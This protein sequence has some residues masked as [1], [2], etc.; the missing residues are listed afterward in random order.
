MRLPALC[1]ALAVLLV[2]AAA[3]AQIRCASG[4]S[5][6]VSEVFAQVNAL[7][8]KGGLKALRMDS[9]LTRAAQ[10]HGCEMRASGFFAHESPTTGTAGER[11]KRAGYTWCRVTENLAKGQDTP[12]QAVQGWMS[13]KG[14]RRNILDGDVVE[15]GI[16]LVPEGPDGGP[17]W[18]QVFA[19]PCP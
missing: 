12:T 1:F 18:V 16:A 17:Y 2:P 11:A 19:A 13:S 10:Q 6:Q 3:S 8:I 7:R 4:G 9:R 15:T 14:H 5:S